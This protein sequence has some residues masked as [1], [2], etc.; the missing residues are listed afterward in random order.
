[1]SQWPVSSSQ[2]AGGEE[3][4]ATTPKL[5]TTNY[6][7]LTNCRSRELTGKPCKAFTLLEIMIAI[8]I[9]GLV[10]IAIFST[11]TAILRAA[12]VGHDA[13]ASIQRARIAVRTIEDSLGSVESFTANQ[14]YYAFLV[15]NGNEASLS[16]VARL[17]KSFPRSGRFGDLDVRRLTFSVESGI[18]SPRELVLRQSPILMEP[19][20]DEREHP[21]VLAKNVQEFSVQLWDQK[22]G[23]WTDEWLQTNQLPTVVMVTLK[24]SDKPYSRTPTEEITRIISLPSVAV[25]PGWQRP[26]GGPIPGQPLQP[27]GAQGGAQIAPGQL[28]PPKQ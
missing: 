1:M 5:Q 12:R 13:A 17:A 16:F 22:L 23:D 26:V 21:L 4:R 14:Q 11:W 18:D 25:Q 15:D 19:D 27:G 20:I 10:L 9:F 8:G 2:A 3:A 24:L 6:E 7:L 28:Q